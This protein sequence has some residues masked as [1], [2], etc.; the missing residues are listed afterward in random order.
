MARLSN[1]MYGPLSGKLGPVIHSTW[2]GQPYVRMRP[3]KRG[4]KRG[5]K[6]KLNQDKFSQT[7]YWLQPL[8]PFVR[9]GFRG[10]S[11]RV[12]G[13]NAAKSFCLKHAFTGE[14]AEQKIDPSRMQLSYGDLPLP[15][16]IKMKRSGDYFLEFSWDKKNNGGNNHDQAMLLAYDCENGR[17][18]MQLTGQFRVSGA[19]KLGL[20]EIKKKN[21]HIYIAFIAHDRSRQSNSVYLGKVST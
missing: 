1:N 4:K 13:F 12:E 19:D 11:P 7:H 6:E 5:V 20:P 21:Y 8:L 2:K 9:I 18:E 15:S 17:S 3:R 10:Y 14:A 16:S